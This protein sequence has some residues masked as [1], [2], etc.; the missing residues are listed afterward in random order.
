M[1]RRTTPSGYTEIGL[2]K[3][4]GDLAVRLDDIRSGHQVPSDIVGGRVSNV[5][6]KPGSLMI[7]ARWICST[8][9]LIISQIL[10]SFGKTITGGTVDLLGYGALSDKMC[11]NCITLL[12]RPHF[13][14]C[15]SKG[16]TADSL[17]S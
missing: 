16:N 8:V 9:I 10:R 2:G 1:S 12:E 15:S 3:F 11:C 14:A 13:D 6:R 7:R 17:F 5:F 4:P